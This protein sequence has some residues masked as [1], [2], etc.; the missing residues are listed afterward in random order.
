MFLSVLLSS[1]ND[2]CWFVCVSVVYRDGLDKPNYQDNRSGFQSGFGD[3]RHLSYQPHQ[4][5]L[6]IQYADDSM[7]GGFK[8]IEN[9][10]LDEIMKLVKEQRE[11][12]DA[13]YTRHK[14]VSSMIK[15]VHVLYIILFTI[16]LL[17]YIFLSMDSLNLLVFR[18]WTL[19]TS[20]IKN[21]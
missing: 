8:S 20:N 5:D 15:D 17:L 9:K 6:D 13:E 3:D 1:G 14:E 7:S 12:E 10:F 16:F 18:S 11:A 2:Q 19:L 4:E 21:S